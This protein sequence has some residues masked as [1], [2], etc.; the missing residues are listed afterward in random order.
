[1]RT[2]TTVFGA[3]AILL[4]MVTM[5]L[6]ASAGTTWDLQ[7]DFSATNNPTGAWSYGWEPYA[8]VNNVYQ[9]NGGFTLYNTV[10]GSDPGWRDSGHQSGDHTPVVWKNL[11][12]GV[13]YGVAPGEVSLH[14]GWD[15][16]FTIARWTA[17]SAGTFNI[18][19]V[20]GV[21]DL[22]AMSYYVLE[23]GA[24][25]YIWLNDPGAETFAFT[26]TLA[27]GAILDFAV[28]VNTRGGYGY[29]NTPLAVTI[30]QP[31]SSVPEPGSLALLGTGILGAAG[32][33][34]RRFMA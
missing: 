3:L 30:T 5:N 14:P 26:E 18:S 17:P 10:F 13:E 31:N 34:R 27:A 20:F 7:A 33:I 32:A 1:M 24:V 23:N 4:F 16:S 22:G 25:Q 19:G 2:R 9:P 8:V 15:G 28:G 29:G 12:S 21:G 6:A 11:S